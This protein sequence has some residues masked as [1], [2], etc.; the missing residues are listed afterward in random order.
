MLFCLTLAKHTS[1]LTEQ[2]MPIKQFKHS[3]QNTVTFS[4]LFFFPF[5]SS[6]P[7]FPLTFFYP[8]CT[9]SLILTCGR[10]KRGTLLTIQKGA[11][12]NVNTHHF[13]QIERT[14]SS[15]VQDL[16]YF[17]QPNVQKYKLNKV[18]RNISVQL[19]KTNEH[20]RIHH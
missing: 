5:L 2:S 9:H 3:Q 8:F 16:H 1:C 6:F 20:T 19:Y 14:I 7:P 11:S 17:S 15:A 4:L 13:D 12:D 10:N 18:K